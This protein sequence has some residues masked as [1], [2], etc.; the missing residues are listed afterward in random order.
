MSIYLNP[1]VAL[2]RLRTEWLVHGKIIVAFDIDST[3][4]PFHASEAN[5]DYAPIHKLLRNLKGLGCILIAFTAAH[6]SRWDGIK[7]K[8]SDIGIVYDYFNQSPP[9]IPGVVR[10]GKVYANAYLDDRA[11]LCEMY[12][13]LNQLVA[14]KAL[15]QALNYQYGTI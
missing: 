14:E 1:N 15:Q 3:V 10:T 6:E 9:T 4:L 5:D 7:Q 13:I 11:G 8:L 2:E 12:S